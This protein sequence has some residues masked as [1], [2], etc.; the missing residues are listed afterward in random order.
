MKTSKNHYLLEALRAYGLNP[1]HWSIRLK[2]AGNSSHHLLATLVNRI[3]ED[4][5]LTGECRLVE[6][7]YG[8]TLQWQNLSLHI[9]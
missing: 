8:P 6:N 1:S 7:S 2:S 4:V 3:E 9:A 5:L